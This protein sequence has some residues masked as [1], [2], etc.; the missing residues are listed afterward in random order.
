MSSIAAGTT[1]GTA[2]V[3]SGDTS[4]TLLLQTNGTTTA[5][6]I[7]TNQVVTL[8]QPLPV[9][10][11]GTGGSATPTAG[12]VVYGTGSAQAVTAAGTSGY[13]LKSNGASAPTWVALS[14][15][16]GDHEYTLTTGNGFGSTNTNIRVFTT[17]ARNVGTAITGA[18]C[19]TLGASA[20]INEAG[21]Y[22]IFYS[23]FDS[24][25]GQW[26]GISLNSASLSTSIQSITSYPERLASNQVVVAGRQLC[27]SVTRLFAVGDVIRPHC[28]ST[29]SGANTTNIFS[30]VKVNS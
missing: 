17:V 13:Y 23:D 15:S 25:T 24:G 26:Y 22:S 3:S 19:A 1:S 11:G 5:V 4:G 30:V 14:T 20:T 16:V 8:A 12:G 18:N 9:A 2:L 27:L 10:S 28:T 7:G 21:I 29:M 6:T